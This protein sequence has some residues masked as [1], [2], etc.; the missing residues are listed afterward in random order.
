MNEAALSTIRG[1]VPPTRNNL[2]HANKVRNADMAEELSALT[3][4]Q[5]L[6]QSTQSTLQIANSVPNLV[7][8]LLQ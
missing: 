6:V 7:L 5:I 8:S 2:S 1:A 3:R 4:A